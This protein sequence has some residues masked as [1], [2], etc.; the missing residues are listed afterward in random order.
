MGEQKNLSEGSSKP[1]RNP[2]I[3]ARVTGWSAQYPTF[4]WCQV[5]PFCKPSSESCNPWMAWTQ[6]DQL[7]KHLAQCYL[8]GRSVEK[9]FKH[10]FMDSEVTAC[11]ESRG[12][13]LRFSKET[14]IMGVMVFTHGTGEQRCTNMKRSPL[15]SCPVLLKAVQQINKWPTLFVNQIQL[16]GRSCVTQ[17]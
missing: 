15:S 10:N 14:E 8:T 5:W 2:S 17:A 4:S 7:W 9:G 11:K 16:K 3:S 12:S 1:K 6:W 13:E